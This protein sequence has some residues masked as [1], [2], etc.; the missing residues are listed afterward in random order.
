MY[1]IYESD[2][3]PTMVV[4]VIMSGYAH[5]EERILGE[6]KKGASFEF[7]CKLDELEEQLNKYINSYSKEARELLDTTE[8]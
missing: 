1:W 6:Y 7:M 5:A 3:L 2:H 4:M 8:P